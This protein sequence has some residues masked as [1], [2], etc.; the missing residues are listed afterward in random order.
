[1]VLKI[2][3][4]IYDLRYEDGRGG[5][6]YKSF[7]L[8]TQT[9]QNII[10]DEYEYVIYTDKHT[11]DTFSLGDV[12]NQQNVVIKIEELNSEY[13]LNTINSVRE[14]K[15]NE[16]EIYDRIYCVK[17]Y[18]EVILNKIKFLLS[19]SEE[20]KNVVWLD[21]GLFGTS[22]HDGWRDYMNVLAH[23]KLFLNKINE[24]IDEYGF[25]SLRGE[26]I[27]VNYELRDRMNAIY[28]TE[29]KLIPGAL[30]GGNNENIQKVLSDYLNIFDLYL[31]TYNGLISEQEVLAI[32]THRNNTKFFNFGDWNDFQ[33]GV[34]EIMDKL[35]TEKYIL[36]KCYE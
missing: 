36:E 1:M 24:K 34:L 20:N 28:N 5:M 21:A 23:S 10:F 26:A 22:C 9:I 18:I 17:N 31:K 6:R 32:L 12:F 8:L 16:G 13:Y 7:P 19:E 27:Q 3:T 15:F 30:F 11:Y 33:R 35:D 29:F 2:I 25:I 4:S 14:T